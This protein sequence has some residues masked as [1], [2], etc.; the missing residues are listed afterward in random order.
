M[1]SADEASVNAVVKHL[2]NGAIPVAFIAALHIEV[3]I[4]VLIPWHE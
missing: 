4:L 2:V 3:L 1:D